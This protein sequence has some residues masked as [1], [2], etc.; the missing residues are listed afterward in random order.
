MDVE[1]KRITLFRH[2]PLRHG[3]YERRHPRILD[4][5]FS[6]RFELD[7][8]AVLHGKVG[9][10]PFLETRH[11]PLA[12][13]GTIVVEFIVLYFRDHT[14]GLRRRPGGYALGQVEHPFRGRSGGK[15][16]CRHDRA[17][18]HTLERQLRCERG[19]GFLRFGCKRAH[20]RYS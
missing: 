12:R 11:L 14:L 18:I 1:E 17:R 19:I 16:R 8:P 5:R 13:V 2:G 20:G 6:V 3:D 10:Q 15:D 4:H 9:N 7:D